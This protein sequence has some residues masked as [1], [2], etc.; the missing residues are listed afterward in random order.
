[1]SVSHGNE[2]DFSHASYVVNIGLI[3]F[4]LE[5]STFVSIAYVMVIKVR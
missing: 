1:M 5:N 2:N 4:L 3:H